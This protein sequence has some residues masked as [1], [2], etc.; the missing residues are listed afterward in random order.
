[1]AVR[2][3]VVVQALNTG[4]RSLLH[5]NH[6]S[7]LVCQIPKRLAISS[8]EWSRTVHKHWR[9]ATR[10]CIHPVSTATYTNNEGTTHACVHQLL[11]YA[12]TMASALCWSSQRNQLALLLSSETLLLQ[13]PLPL[14]H[15]QPLFHCL[16]PPL[17]LM[18]LL[19]EPC[20]KP[21]L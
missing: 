11:H 15:Q 1:M 2:L 8:C 4:D 21:S 5:Q 14:L 7:G 16:L 19:L 20:L 12:N 10:G 6:W 17:L 18:P 3:K 13:Q 9:I